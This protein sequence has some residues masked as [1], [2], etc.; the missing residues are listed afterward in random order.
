M[1]VDIYNKVEIIIA[2]CETCTSVSDKPPKQNYLLGR[3]YWDKCNPIK[4]QDWSQCPQSGTSM[5]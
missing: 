5:L 1:L 4:S 3:T 2:K